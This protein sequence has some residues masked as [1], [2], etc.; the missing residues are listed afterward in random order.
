MFEVLQLFAEDEG[1]RGSRRASRRAARSRKNPDFG[2]AAR[3]PFLAVSRNLELLAP[4]GLAI[5]QEAKLALILGKRDGTG[6]G[7]LGFPAFLGFA[8]GGVLWRQ[9]DPSGCAPG[10]RAQQHKTHQWPAHAFTRPASLFLMCAEPA[11]P[12]G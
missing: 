9:A 10:Q 7:G 3:C 1:L 4:N 5:E 11:L 2:C 12:D 8:L 6:G